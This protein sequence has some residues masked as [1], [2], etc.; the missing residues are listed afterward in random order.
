VVK[1]S[2][3]DGKLGELVYG[4]LNSNVHNILVNSGNQDFLLSKQGVLFSRRH[5]D[6]ILDE[7]KIREKTQYS[8]L[9]KYSS[10]G[11]GLGS[12]IDKFT[13]EILLDLK[14]D[15]FGFD[16]PYFNEFRDLETYNTLNELES[17]ILGKEK[18]S[19]T[20]SES[21]LFSVYFISRQLSFGEKALNQ[22]ILPYVKQNNIL[23]KNFKNGKK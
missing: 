14:T 13:S 19:S 3:K 15:P 22:C 23:E 11:N 21:I 18:C 16:V 17:K 6:S 9:G 10:F 20:L 4:Y 8:G 12:R 1:N 7:I 2:L 5:M